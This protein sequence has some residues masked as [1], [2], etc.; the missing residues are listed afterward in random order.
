MAPPPDWSRRWRHGGLLAAGTED[1][2]AAAHAVHLAQFPALHEAPHQL[3]IGA[4]PMIHVHHDDLVLLLRRL[5]DARGGRRVH[6]EGALAEDVQVRR[7]RRED[8]A[9]VQVRRGA[10]DQCIERLVVE[11]LLDA[12]ER[13]GNAEPVGEGPGLGTVGIGERHDLHALGALEHRQVC[14]LRHCPCA[15]DREPK[16]IAHDVTPCCLARAQ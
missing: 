10:D 15:D 12:L 11:H 16:W 2:P 3:R 5:H 6:G 9:L 7:E 8:V 4:V 13:V 14:H 1:V